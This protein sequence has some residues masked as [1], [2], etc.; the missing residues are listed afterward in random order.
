ML[1]QGKINGF[2]RV[3]PIHLSAMHPPFKFST[4]VMAHNQLEHQTHLKKKL[5][6]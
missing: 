5:E 2:G 3:T 1:V 6:T 4:Y